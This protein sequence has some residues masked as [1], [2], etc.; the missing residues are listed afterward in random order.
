MNG[1]THYA[2]SL[3]I[4]LVIFKYMKKEEASK[5][6]NILLYSI[7]FFVNFFFHAILDAIAVMTY[8]PS[9][10]NWGEPVYTSWH[11]FVYSAEAIGGI[12]FLR[13]DIRYAVGLIGSVGYDIWDWSIGRALGERLGFSLPRLHNSADWLRDS[14]FFWLPNLTNDPLAAII[15]ILF[16]I[17][18]I[19]IWLILDKQKIIDP[20]KPASV[21]AIIA[22]VLFFGFW[23]VLNLF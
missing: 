16:I 23:R 19:I 15:E 8:H 14:I 20:A 11:I 3:I 7:I 1:I 18:F 13:K 21:K 17:I 22:L 4:S 9:S 12:I 2:S 10:A 5:E 6:Y